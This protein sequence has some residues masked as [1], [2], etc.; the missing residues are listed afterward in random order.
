M[1]IWQDKSATQ[2]LSLQQ[3]HLFAVTSPRCQLLPEA[4]DDPVPEVLEREEDHPL[5]PADEPPD[6]V[7]GLGQLVGVVI[8][9]TRGRQV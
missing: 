3:C 9:A 7:E 1:P 8:A 2:Q 6:P 5:D 4:V